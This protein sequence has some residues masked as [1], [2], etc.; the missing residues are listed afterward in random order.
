MEVY[1]FAAD[2]AEALANKPA[3]IEN[4]LKEAKTIDHVKIDLT[5]E[6]KIGNILCGIIILLYSLLL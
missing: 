1:L 3:K 2:L 4:A 6:S 5:I